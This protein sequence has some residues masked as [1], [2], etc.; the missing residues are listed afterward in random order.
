MSLTSA[1]GG[2]RIGS[3]SSASVE[4][5]SNDNPYGVVSFNTSTF[6]A[7]EAGTDSL[8]MVPVVRRYGTAYIWNMCVDVQ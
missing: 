7:T 8:A 1:T 2:A 4:I 3:S 5:V 6:A